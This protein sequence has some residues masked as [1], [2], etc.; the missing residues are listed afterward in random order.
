[1]AT[2]KIE[3]SGEEVEDILINAVR[4]KFSIPSKTKLQLDWSEEHDATI[5]SNDVAD[6][7]PNWLEDD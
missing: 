5:S 4:K 2:F 1:M 7:N 6:S 3:L